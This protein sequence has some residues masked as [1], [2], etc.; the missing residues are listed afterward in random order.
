MMSGMKHRFSFSN[1]DVSNT[2]K[3]EIMNYK[4]LGIIAI[5]FKG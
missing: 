4:T 2:P 3:L 5:T 1:F